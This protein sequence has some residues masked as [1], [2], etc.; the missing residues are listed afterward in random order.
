[1]LERTAAGHQNER[2]PLHI[3]S[4][5]HPKEGAPVRTL[6]ELELA[7]PLSYLLDNASQ[8]LLTTAC[9]SP[10][11][12]PLHPA[13]L[14]PSTPTA[15]FHPLPPGL[16]MPEEHRQLQRRKTRG[17][18]LLPGVTYPGTDTC[19]PGSHLLL[20]SFLA[21]AKVTAAPATPHWLRRR[22]LRPC[23]EALGGCRPALSRHPTPWPS[24]AGAPLGSAAAA[25]PCLRPACVLGGGKRS[26][27]SM[28]AHELS[29]LPPF[30]N[31]QGIAPPSWPFPELQIS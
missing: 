24:A 31:C 13:S 7:F 21:L 30:L 19:S 28:Q 15:V 23:Q 1:M 5:T 12:V 2:Y 10:M 8:L 20:L 18:E 14:N 27:R 26:A 6:L 29:S 16:C 17:D 11:N 9:H 3:P 22:P 25:L 4:H